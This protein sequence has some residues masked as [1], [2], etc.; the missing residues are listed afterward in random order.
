MQRFFRLVKVTLKGIIW[1]CGLCNHSRNIKHGKKIVCI[2]CGASEKKNSINS[3]DMETNII[4]RP[5]H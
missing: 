5:I 4:T 1:Q 2:Y 3:Y